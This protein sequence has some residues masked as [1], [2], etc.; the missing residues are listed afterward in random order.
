MEAR[1]ALAETTQLSEEGVELALRDHL[2]IDATHE[3]RASLRAWC[4]EAPRCHVVLSAH[5]CTAALR[6]I[7]LALE[8]APEVIVKP[9]RRDPV[10]ATLLVRELA[11]RGVAI[12]LSP[13][14]DASPGDEVHA[15]GSDASLSSLRRRLPSGV[16]F[17][18]HGSGF[19]FAVIGAEDS[20]DVGSAALAR[21]IAVFD[22]RGCLSP[23][24]VL[25]IGSTEAARAFAHATN[26]ALLELGARVPRGVLDE[27]ERASV[28]T[29]RASYAAI[30]E[31]WS[32]RDHVVAFAEELPSLELPPAARTLLVIGVP[33]AAAAAR[34]VSPL[35]RYVTTLGTVGKITDLT[36]PTPTA[37]AELAR[38]V[39]TLSGAAR[40]VRLAVL[41]RMQRPPLDGPVDRRHP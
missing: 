36:A 18:G 4:N 13:G 24:F 10:L 41:G 7:A 16:R 30:G 9:S 31:V 23:R 2:E 15:Y 29:F 39:L 25:L 26:D 33:N 8:T 37:E 34:L 28:A 21:D 19:G 38:E 35:S 17:R 14:L 27:P 22:Q 32:N 40:G 6:A 20:F 11:K 12:S 3:E 5:V 1:S